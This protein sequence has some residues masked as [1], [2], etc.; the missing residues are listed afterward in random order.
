LVTNPV[1]PPS[2][3]CHPVSSIAPPGLI[4]DDVRSEP[5]RFVIKA[6]G[7]TAACPHAFAF[8]ARDGYVEQMLV[9]TL[10]PGKNVL[11]DN[12]GS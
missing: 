12:L 3:P 1:T 4:L 5:N 2:S 9:P 6:H 7:S 11:M 10:S 8:A